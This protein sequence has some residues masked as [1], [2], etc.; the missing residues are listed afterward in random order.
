M[1]TNPFD[2]QVGGSCYRDMKLQPGLFAEL[3]MLS[4][5]E[6]SIIKRIC[7]YHYDHDPEELQKIIHECELLMEINQGSAIASSSQVA[8]S[9]GDLPCEKQP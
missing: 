4:Y 5:F 8:N 6:G 2:R 9:F 3:N 1:N 7:S